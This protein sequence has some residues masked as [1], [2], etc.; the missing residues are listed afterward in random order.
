MAKFN[1]SRANEQNR[2]TRHRDEYVPFEE[3]HIMSDCSQGW[4]THSTSW[5][6]KKKKHH[7]RK[8][9]ENPSPI[10]S[11]PNKNLR[12]LKTNNGT[13]A[14]VVTKDER[15]RFAAEKRL[16]ERK[17]SSEIPKPLP[18]FD[19]TIVALVINISESELIEI[20][21]AIATSD[22]YFFQH[23]PLQLPVWSINQIF[24]YVNGNYY[25]VKGFIRWREKDIVISKVTLKPDN[26]NFLT[27]CSSESISLT[28][29]I[30]GTLYK[31]INNEE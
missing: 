23:A 16:S 3:T 9:C 26:G 17:N 6:S 4:Y 30:S 27:K 28:P 8:K 2:M 14:H 13:I 18:G 7:R 5:K 12:I 1:W 31:S 11:V 25:N 15:K 10:E 20:Q 21:K 22:Y 19:S 29:Q 24:F